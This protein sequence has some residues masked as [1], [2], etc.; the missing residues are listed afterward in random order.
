[1]RIDARHI[2]QSGRIV[3]RIGD[4]HIDFRVSTL[5]TQFGENVVLRILDSSKLVESDLGKLGVPPE[6]RDPLLE[7]CERSQG[8][9]LVTGPTGSGKTTTL[10]HVLNHLHCTYPQ[11]GISTIE[12]PIEYVLEGI[13]QSEVNEARGLTYAAILKE[14]LRQD[15]D[16][17]MVGE[18]RNLEEAQLAFTAALT[19]HVVFS[20]LH[21]NDGATTVRRLVDMGMEPYN[22]STAINC[23][24]SQRLAKRICEHC[25][26]DY[27]PSEREVQRVRRTIPDFNPARFNI[28]KGQGCEHCQEGYKGRVG[29]YELLLVD[30]EI[31][32]LISQNSTDSEIRAAAVRNGMK[33]LRMAGLELAF[34]GVTTLEEV[35]GVTDIIL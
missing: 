33:T 4:R 15:P 7:Q 17:I 32:Q 29:I 26:A 2:P 11:K 10:Y 5:P 25:A 30:A 22:V 21:T 8:I 28:K 31:K 18:I 19:G 16:V 34:R 3:A 24:L 35:F 1:M 13:V 23:V 14:K 20:T 6:V 9:V 12:N 27:I